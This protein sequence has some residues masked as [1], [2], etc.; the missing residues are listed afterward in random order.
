MIQFA[1]M[2]GIYPNLAN[3]CIFWLIWLM[4][5]LK[6]VSDSVR[7]EFQKRAAR[8]ILKAGF[9]TPSEQLFKE[10]NWLPFPKR[11][12]YHTCLTVYKSITGQAPEYISSMLKYVC[13]HH[14]RQ[15]RSTVLDLLHIPR[16]HSAYFDRAFS[17]HGPKLWNSLSTDIRNSTSINRFKRELKRYLLYN[18]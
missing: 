4:C 8:M 6:L 10:L 15:T 1:R 13:E 16:L 7:N 18:N 2:H 9:M 17:V 14:E 12:Q 11:V 5:I 3:I